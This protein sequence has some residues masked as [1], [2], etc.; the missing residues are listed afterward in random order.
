MCSL[1]KYLPSTPYPVQNRSFVLCIKTVNCHLA[2][3]AI[4]AEPLPE[5]VKQPTTHVRPE[6]QHVTLAART[7]HTRTLNLPTC[8][9]KNLSRGPSLRS[10]PERRHRKSTGLVHWPDLVIILLML[11]HALGADGLMREG[12][13]EGMQEA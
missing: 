7:H 9:L 5:E 4:A 1:Y 6:P 12:R 13:P 3:S 11:T 10:S 8:R 2:A